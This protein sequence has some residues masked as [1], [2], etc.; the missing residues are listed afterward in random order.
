MRY[1]A[2]SDFANPPGNPVVIEDIKDEK[3]AVVRAQAPVVLNGKP[4]K[5]HVQK[6][7]VFTIG[8]ATEYK[9][10]SPAERT[11]VAQL[12]VARKIA[13]AT[14]ANVKRIDAEVKDDKARAE[15]DAQAA[16][17]LRGPTMAEIMAALPNLIASAVAAAVPRK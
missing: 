6:G 1:I 11:L 2:T 4:C 5:T 12:M 9:D 13:D 14:D 7:A 10:L 8:T 3:G 17:S 16:A 15:R